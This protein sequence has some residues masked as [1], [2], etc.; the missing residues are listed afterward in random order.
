MKNKP[1]LPP[2]ERDQTWASNKAGERD[3]RVKIA[4]V[5][6]EHAECYVWRKGRTASPKRQRIRLS[7]FNTT[8]NGFRLLSTKEEQS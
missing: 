4:D 6:A 2:V 3:V 7:R 5:G 8:A 1:E